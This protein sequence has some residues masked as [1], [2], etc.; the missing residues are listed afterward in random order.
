VARLQPPGGKL[1]I[2]VALLCCAPPLL[3]DDRLPAVPGAPSAL[4]AEPGGDG[5][6]INVD[7]F[8]L[9]PVTAAE[10]AGAGSLPQS[11]PRMRALAAGGSLRADGGLQV[12]P[13]SATVE[14]ELPALWEYRRR[15]GE[16]AGNLPRVRVDVE[17]SSGSAYPAAGHDGSP[18]S[19][20]V[21]ASQVSR[22]DGGDG[23]EI[24][25]GGVILVIPVEALQGRGKL[26]TR[27]R[28]T[29]EA[30]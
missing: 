24:L 30:I 3:A 11:A 13:L 25:V 10:L 6:R 5:L 16:S 18:R 26:R 7:R 21:R 15:R 28:I 14:R 9:E 27:L 1:T 12:S 17:S 2:A 19:V 29:V 8:E 4:A 23:T 22:R 20:Q